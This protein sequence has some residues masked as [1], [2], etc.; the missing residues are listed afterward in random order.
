MPRVLCQRIG[1]TATQALTCPPILSRHYASM[2]QDGLQI[3]GPLGGGGVRL[4]TWAERPNS[5]VFTSAR[6]LV[7]NFVRDLARNLVWNFRRKAESLRF[8]LRTPKFRPNPHLP[9][10][11][12]RS[13]HAWVPLC[14]CAESPCPTPSPPENYIIVKPAT[15]SHCHAISRRGRAAGRFHTLSKRPTT[16]RENM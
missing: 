5:F 10:F 11:Q 7:L 4:H 14:P 6:N 15:G 12:A 3:A 2:I 8:Y 9:P 16:L 13:S 1:V